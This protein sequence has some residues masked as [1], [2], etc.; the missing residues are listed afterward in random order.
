[1]SFDDFSGFMLVTEMHYRA[2]L[3]SQYLSENRQKLV[4]HEPKKLTT[5]QSIENHSIPSEFTPMF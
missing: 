4:G 3:T 5:I 1:M 2:W